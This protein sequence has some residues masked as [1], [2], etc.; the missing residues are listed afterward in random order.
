L[1]GV[2]ARKCLWRFGYQIR[3]N[4]SGSAETY[5][6]SEKTD[7]ID[8]F[9]SHSWH[10]NST[11]KVLTLLYHYNGTAAAVASLIIACA[12]MLVRDLNHTGMFGR[13]TCS[14]HAD[15]LSANFYCSIRLAPPLY[16]PYCERNHACCYD[17]TNSVDGQCPNGC[18]SEMPIQ[19]PFDGAF[20]T[21][22]LVLFFWQS[23]SLVFLDRVP[24]DANESRMM[25]FVRMIILISS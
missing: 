12:L 4:V 21:Y 13:T 17:V 5:E 9:W 19:W 6:L 8:G 10:A 3:N 16:S 7:R 20:L 14:T 2:R 18:P 11:W 15:C 24:K 23:R 22:F 25:L 1:R